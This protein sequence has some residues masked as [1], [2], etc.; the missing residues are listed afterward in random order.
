MLHCHIA[1]HATP[2][3]HPWLHVRCGWPRRMY[4][5]RKHQHFGCEIPLR[6]YKCDCRDER[7]TPC[8]ESRRARDSTRESFAEY[9]I[10]PKDVRS[11]TAA[12]SKSII[13]KKLPSKSDDI[14]STLSEAMTNR[15]QGQFIWLKMQEESLR[16]GMNKKQLQSAIENTPTGLD[17]L[18]DRSWTR[19]TRL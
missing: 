8:C 14:R 13:D 11:D 17:H 12:Y 10:T 19:I 15:C 4:L 5:V 7:T 18:Y 3:H 16:R 1:L 9:R 2:P 6:C